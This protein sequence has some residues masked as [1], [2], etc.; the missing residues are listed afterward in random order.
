[1]IKIAYNHQVFSWQRY[2]GISRYVYELATHLSRQADLEVKVLAMAYI[3]EY[4]KQCPSDVV[5]GKKIPYIPSR[6]FQKMTERF[7]N[8]FSKLWQQKNL[9][10]IVHHTFYSTESFAHPKAKVVVTVHDMIHEKFSQFFQD[11]DIFNRLDDTSQ[12]KKRSV[13][14]ADVIICVSENTKKDLIEFFNVDENKIKVVYHGFSNLEGNPQTVQMNLPKPYIL[15]VGDRGRYKNFE[16]FIKAYGNSQQLKQNFQVV[17]FGGGA[18]SQEEQSLMMSLGL[19]D[20]K[21]LQLSGDDGILA[22][23]YRQAAVFVYPSL[24]EGF[25]IPLLEAMSLQCP[26]VCSQISSIPEVAGD[27]AEY[28]D[29]NDLENIAEVLEK[30][31]FSEQHSAKLMQLGQE[32]I[33]QFSWEK[34]A[35]KTKEVYLSL[36]E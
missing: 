33:Q 2:G 24:Y 1:M 6:Q 13:E 27:A 15:Y 23:C 12:I 18:F 10:D 14:Q 25:G 34:C 9:P 29:P 21:V 26:V 30:V 35:Q 20:K 8:A 3:N 22:S 7:N 19:N 5:V 11:K 17:C 16:S 28:F 4:L 36:M 31:L 32:R